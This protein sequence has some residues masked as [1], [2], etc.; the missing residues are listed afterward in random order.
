MLPHHPL[1]S[2]PDHVLGAIFSGLTPQSL[3]VCSQ[4]CT[5]WRDLPYEYLPQTLHVQAGAQATGIL[6]AGLHRCRC[7]CRRQC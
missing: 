1:Q 4:V 2:L 6:N 5:A 3:A 7:L